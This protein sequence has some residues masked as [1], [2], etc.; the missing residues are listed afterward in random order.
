[1]KRGWAINLGGGF[2]HCCYNEGGGFCAYSDITLCYRYVR[3][4]YPKAKK[5]MIIDL[6]AHQGNG[7]ENDKLH[8]KDE[9]LFIVDMYNPSI[10]PSDK[11]AKMAID[12]PIYAFNGIE[13]KEYLGKLRDGLDTAFATFNPDFIVYNAGTDILIGDPLG[14]LSVSPKGVIERDSMVFAY[15]IY[16]KIPIVMFLSGGY[17]QTNARV[18]ADSIINL[19]KTYNLF[20]SNSP[21]VETLE[22]CKLCSKSYDPESNPK[23]QCLHS[24]PWHSSF[25]DCSYLKCGIG[26]GPSYIGCQHWGCCYEIDPENKVCPKSL[27]H[28]PRIK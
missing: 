11:P 9:N 25:S 6:D 8:F 14:D 21:S 27:P 22:L 24:K 18:I 3:H 13:D 4:H 16:Q 12:I 7:H 23:G 28:E 17:Q 19:N 2:H 26:L 15:A 10:Y 1:M 5:I 20:N